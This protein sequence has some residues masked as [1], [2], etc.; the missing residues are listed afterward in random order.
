MWCGRKKWGSLRLRQRIWCQCSRTSA[1][2]TFPSRWHSKELW[3]QSFPKNWESSHQSE[4]G[5]PESGQLKGS[6][7]W[8]P[9]PSETLLQFGY[10]SGAKPPYKSSLRKW[11]KR[12]ITSY[13]FFSHFRL[14]LIRFSRFLKQHKTC[15]A[16]A[17]VRWVHCPQSQIPLLKH[18]PLQL[19]KDFTS[20]SVLASTGISPHLEGHG[21]EKLSVNYKIP[22]LIIVLFELWT[23]RRTW[24][25][26]A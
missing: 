25:H 12:D 20:I 17:K 21:P 15:L 14:W 6:L 8:C 5:D 4:G 13:C 7:G 24:A 3:L 2:G 18:F 22:T 1:L 16:E 9:L 19:W 10:Q 23:R 26:M 11:F